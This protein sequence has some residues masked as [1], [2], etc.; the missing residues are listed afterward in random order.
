MRAELLI[1]ADDMTGALDTGVQ[2]AKQGILS[3]VIA[4]PESDPDWA[5][6]DAEVLIVH[7]SSRH[8]SLLQAYEKV[9]RIVSEAVQADIPYIYKKTDSALRGNIGAELSAA[10]HASGADCLSF[11]P[12]YPAMNRT[13]R[14]GILL[15]DGIPVSDSIF[16]KDPYNPVLTSRIAGIIHGQ[17]SLAVRMMDETDGTGIILAD[18]E[19]DEDLKT[20]GLRMKQKKMLRVSAGCAGFAAYLPELLELKR[21][22]TPEIPDPG[23]R[24]LVISGSLNPVTLKQ[25]DNA[26]ENG[27]ARIR[28]NDDQKLNAL[29]A[30][31][32]DISG[33]WTVLDSSDAIEQDAFTAAEERDELRN[34]IAG[35]LGMLAARISEAYQGTIMI[36]GGDTIA[37]CLKQME[38]T[39]LKIIAEV[40]PGVVLSEMLAKGRTRLLL[41]KSGGFGAQT[42]PVDLKKWMEDKHRE[43]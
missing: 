35:N 27:F 8:L 40:F 31:L 16:G 43:V 41:S 22:M 33:R 42:L 14:N 32:P 7:T 9:Y 26:E 23:D 36:I 30:D 24:L 13:V 37:A 4:D 1:T 21:G 3:S 6:T 34:V 29:H 19:T 28:L 18:A 17:T 2:L 5:K 20:A 10:L 11:L 12:A 38:C 15:I 39:H 25:L